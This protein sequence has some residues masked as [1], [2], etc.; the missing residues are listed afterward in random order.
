MLS[1]IIYM[2]IVL[3]KPFEKLNIYQHFNFQEKQPREQ[4]SQEGFA[5]NVSNIEKL[6]EVML[7]GY[8]ININRQAFQCAQCTP[9]NLV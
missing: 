3:K 7:K 4:K 5:L 8:L 6:Y 1:G 9:S 2:K